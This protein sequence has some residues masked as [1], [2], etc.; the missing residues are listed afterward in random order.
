MVDFLQQGE[1]FKG[2][3]GPGRPKLSLL[4]SAFADHLSDLASA[5]GTFPSRSLVKGAL[6]QQNFQIGFLQLR[7]GKVRAE[8]PL[9]RKDFSGLILRHIPGDGGDIL[10]ALVALIPGK[11]LILQQHLP[12]GAVA[13]GL[14]A[15]FVL[16]H[17]FKQLSLFLVPGVLPV[18]AEASPLGQMEQHPGK[19]FPAQLFVQG[20]HPQGVDVRQL[21]VEKAVQLLPPQQPGRD[22][23]LSDALFSVPVPAKAASCAPGL[24][25]G[26]GQRRA[27]FRM[28]C[29]VENPA[30][31]VD[32][33]P[34][35]LLPVQCQD[36]P[37]H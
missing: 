28:L 18:G 35:L 7:S 4:E 25:A 24:P 12:G 37:A 9:G 2:I 10:P 3:A 8:A 34:G 19:F 31:H 20:F 15:L 6:A 13:H 27:G 21:P 23:Q 33:A 17:R 14:H 22:D 1:V 32:N 26:K 36:G 16:A 30:A 29:R 5:V 11:G